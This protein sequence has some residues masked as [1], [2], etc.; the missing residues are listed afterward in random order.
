[1]IKHVLNFIQYLTGP[2][3][4]GDGNHKFLK[5]KLFMILILTLTFSSGLMSQEKMDKTMKMDP[6]AQTDHDKD[7]LM[8]KDG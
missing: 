5:M 1:M 3:L 6:K 7:H 8:M 2:L 4:F